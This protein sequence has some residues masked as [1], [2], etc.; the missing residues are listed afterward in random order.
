MSVD[1][2]IIL[3]NS[4]RPIIQ[5]GFRSTNATYPLLH[6]DTLNNALASSPQKE[7]VDPVLYVPG[8]ISDGKHSACCHVKCGDVRILAPIRGDVDPLFAFAFIHTFVEILQDYFGTLSAATLRD[9]FDVVYQLLEETLDSIGYPNTTSPNQLRDIVL[10][11]SLLHKILSVTGVS[12]LSNAG[13]GNITPF[14][15]PIPWRKAGLRYNNNEIYFDVTEVLKAI[16]G[17]TGTLYCEVQGKVD[18]NSRLSGTPDLQLTFTNPD[19]LVDASFHS[20]V[21]LRRW[22]RDKALSFVPP[23]GR[24]TLMEYRYLPPTSRSLSAPSTQV[25]VPFT[26]KP[27]VTIEED[28][29]SFSVSL[30]SRLST[31]LFDEIVVEFYL[32]DGSSGVNCTASHGTSWSF[33]SRTSKI[34]WDLK[35]VPPS[36]THTL[37]GSWASSKKYPRPAAAFR[38]K[39]D[40]A[41]YSYSSIKIDQLRMS[42][43]T[44]KPFKGFRANSKGDVDWRW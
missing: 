29:G 27:V 11:P 3:E 31:R 30:T 32:G 24:F 13:H 42:G 7:D 35:T 40:I 41:K 4:G 34:R 36:G 17:P 6:I 15:S 2:I 44:Y 19:Y 21:R 43:E 18:S 10:P 38:V 25:P 28:G 9:N 22:Q 5:S 23:D 20:C 39:Y 14:S 1:G 33:D 8:Y 37:R 26:L 12:G 16:A